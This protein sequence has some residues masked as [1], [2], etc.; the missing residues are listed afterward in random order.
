M[1]NL[2]LPWLYDF[3]SKQSY[4]MKS[5]AFYISDN[6][7]RLEIGIAAVIDESAFVP[8]KC[9][10]NAQREKI[11]R[12]T[13][14]NSHIVL[15][16]LI[17]VTHVKQ[18]THAHLI[19]NFSSFIALPCCQDLSNVFNNEC[20]RGYLLLSIETPHYSL[21]FF[22]LQMSCFPHTFDQG[23]PLVS[24][25]RLHQEIHAK[26]LITS[27]TGVAL[28]ESQ[29]SI[30]GLD[31]PVLDAYHSVILVVLSLVSWIYQRLVV[32]IA[33]AFFGYLA[34]ISALTKSDSSFI[35]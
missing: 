31:C 12:A 29:S 21:E 11:L 13:I 22:S 6:I 19:I 14:L 9:G 33:C 26:V 5:V 24:I 17:W 30:V 10:I 34:T 35:L 27:A 4:F 2:F 20:T 25:L 15:I 16:M 3:N 23:F 18:V 28:I 32:F 7:E 8:M 1:I